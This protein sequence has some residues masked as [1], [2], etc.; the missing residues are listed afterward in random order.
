[1]MEYSVKLYTALEPKTVIFQGFST[2]AGVT[3][4]INMANLND[5]AARHQSLATL[6][7]EGEVYISAN[8]LVPYET[9]IYKRI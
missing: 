1:M 7:N 8:D 9:K 6:H 3:T 2:L 5:P 4:F